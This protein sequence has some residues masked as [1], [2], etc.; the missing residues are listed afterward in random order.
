MHKLFGVQKSYPK[1]S[2]QIHELVHS[3][4]LAKY[5]KNIVLHKVIHII[6]I[7]SEKFVEEKRNG[8]KQMFCYFFLKWV[9]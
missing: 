1:F 6:H 2:Q 8:R 5:G 3:D 9:F 7:F 4:R